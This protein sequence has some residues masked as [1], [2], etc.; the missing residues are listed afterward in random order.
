MLTFIKFKKT[1]CEI[2]NFAHLFSF[3][4]S[5]LVRKTY[6]VNYSVC[7]RILH[8]PNDCSTTRHFPFLV[9]GSVRAT[10]GKLWPQ[11]CQLL[12]PKMHCV[13]GR[14]LL[15]FLYNY[16]RHGT[17]SQATPRLL[18]AWNSES[19]SLTIV[20]SI[21]FSLEDQFSATEDAVVDLDSFCIPTM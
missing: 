15:G 16:S 11:N 18:N 9:W 3:F 7:V 4:L 19:K 13:L 20:C 1:T 12:S 8:I 5:V 2:F 17:Y 21:Y 14:R 10:T 6:L